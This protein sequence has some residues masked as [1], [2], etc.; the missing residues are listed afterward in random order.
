MGLEEQKVSMR[1]YDKP[2]LKE[3]F[4]NI[5]EKVAQVRDRMETRRQEAAIKQNEAL[6][7]RLKEQRARYKGLKREDKLYNL[8]RKSEKIQAK[9]GSRVGSQTGFNQPSIFGDSLFPKQSSG[10]D[11]IFGGGNIFGNDLFAPL[12][13]NGTRRK[14]YSRGHQKKK[15]R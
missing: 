10:N 6:D 2:S 11:T 14:G 8:Q 9:L 13:G 3:R 15:R 12:G 5:R 4:S 7:K 1:K